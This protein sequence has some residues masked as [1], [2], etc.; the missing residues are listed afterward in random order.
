MGIHMVLAVTSRGNATSL[1]KT[2]AEQMK[3][4]QPAVHL[5]ISRKSLNLRPLD[6]INL[7][8]QSALWIQIEKVKLNKDNNSVPNDYIPCFLCA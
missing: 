2:A 3:D 4:L 1:L 8:S 7:A 5:L 6:Q